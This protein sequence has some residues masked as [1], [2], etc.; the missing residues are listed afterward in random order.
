MSLFYCYLAQTT[1]DISRR[2]YNSTMRLQHKRVAH[3]NAVSCGLILSSALLLVAQLAE[4]PAHA[5]PGDQASERST[6]SDFYRTTEFMTIGIIDKLSRKADVMQDKSKS[7]D[8]IKTLDS[9]I[10]EG[11]GV[12][13]P[14]ILP[15]QGGYCILI[16]H[17]LSESMRVA[18]SS[19]VGLLLVTL[20]ATRSAIG[21]KQPPV[22]IYR[23][24]AWPIRN[25]LLMQ[26]SDNQVKTSTNIPAFQYLH[27]KNKL[28]E[29]DKKLRIEWHGPDNNQALNTFSHRKY[30]LT[31]H[32]KYGDFMGESILAD[33]RHRLS[34]LPYLPGQGPP[35]V[36]REMVAVL[37]KFTPAQQSTSANELARTNRKVQYCFQRHNAYAAYL[38]VYSPITKKVDEYLLTLDNNH[39]NLAR[40]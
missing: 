13:S 27:S 8:K 39:P 11:D 10:P 22:V 36:V 7:A 40:N 14:T 1:S 3:A 5:R 17:R 18:S 28:S 20:S 37:L 24:N 33:L 25:R 4:L 32:S 38:A 16:N 6:F 26:T 31:R 35:D 34:P 23:N 29:V 15:K 9:L 19:Y 2:P 12:R 30:W 21:S